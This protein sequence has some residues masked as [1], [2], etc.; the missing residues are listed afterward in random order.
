MAYS[1]TSLKN[2][3]I[4]ACSQGCSRSPLI[5]NRCIRWYLCVVNISVSCHFLHMQ[6]ISH[7]TV[8]HIYFRMINQLAQTSFL[9]TGECA[10]IWFP[11]LC[12]QYRYLWILWKE[13][14]SDF[15]RKTFQI[16]G[17]MEERFPFFPFTFDGMKRSREWREIAT[18]ACLVISCCSVT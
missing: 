8:F 3:R 6:L 16:E 4:V 18:G 2:T 13:T 9:Y 1:L 7:S 17:N 14:V 10:G 12:D 5:P 15:K 11:F